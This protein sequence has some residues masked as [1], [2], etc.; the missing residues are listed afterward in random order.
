[1]DTIT[2]HWHRC[3]GLIGGLAMTL[4]PPS[5][6]AQSPK[7]GNPM[8]PNTG[9]PRPGRVSPHLP[10]PEF[11]PCPTDKQLFIIAFPEGQGDDDSSPRP[12]PASH[13]LVYWPYRPSEISSLT[14]R[15][16][17]NS[18]Q[19][20][21][22]DSVR[23]FRAPAKPGW[24]LLGLDD[25]VRSKLALATEYIW[26]ISAKCSLNSTRDDF[27]L[28]QNLSPPLTQS[29][30]IDQTNGSSF[31]QQ[32]VLLFRR[33]CAPN[34]TDFDRDNWRVFLNQADSTEWA[35]YPPV[36]QLETLTETSNQPMVVPVK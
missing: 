6:I 13:I 12:V 1:M 10:R 25:D 7:S 3:L 8:P 32:G 23:T 29:S 27:K 19:E 4:L 17:P 35:N 30:Q 36:C 26:E 2:S 31:F 5:V 18:S 15:L 22:P 28:T 14:L 11:T 24:L 34:A 9:T 16:V 33:I 20:L 21:A